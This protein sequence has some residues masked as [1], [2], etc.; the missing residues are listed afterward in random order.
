MTRFQANATLLLAAFLWGSGNVAQQTVL[1]HIGPLMAT[2]LKSLVA[3]LV[4]LPYCMTR[5]IPASPLGWHGA[6]IGL[7]VILSFCL[8]FTALQM[9]YGM[10]SVTN[11]GFLVNTATVLTPILAWLL[12]RNRPGQM[13]WL[14]AIATF[15]GAALMSGASS[16]SL[17]PGDL[18]CLASAVCFAVWMI[19]LGEFVNRYGRAGPVTI[20]QFAATASLC[21]PLGAVAEAPT[22]SALG[23]AL[24][25]LLYLGIVSTA[26]GYLLQAIAQRHTSASE[27]AVIVSA[28]AVFGALGAYAI[29]GETLTPGRAIGAFLISA[30]IVLVQIRFGTL[31]RGAPLAPAPLPSQTAAGE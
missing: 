14:A 18:L 26:G 10:T 6:I 28:E 13:V 19:A 20:L 29:L 25:E 3:A 2:G 27:A 15:S 16:G 8:A 1:E 17:G 7:T 23:A 9:G 30:G 31:R 22:L 24:P 21:I 5:P 4:I 12:L 11:A